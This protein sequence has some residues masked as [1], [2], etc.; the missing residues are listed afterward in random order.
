[1]KNMPTSQPHVQ[2]NQLKHQSI[3]FYQYKKKGKMR[4]TLHFTGQSQAPSTRNSNRKA[5]INQKLSNPYKLVPSHSTKP[6]TG[7]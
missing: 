4:E 2:V 1:M 6:I 7:S 5:T 3:S